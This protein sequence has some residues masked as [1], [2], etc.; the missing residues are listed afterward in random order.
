MI[1][2]INSLYLFLYFIYI[3]NM[4]Y[5]IINIE[6]IKLHLNNIFSLENRKKNTNLLSNFIIE[7]LNKLTNS[8]STYSFYILI[9][10]HYIIVFIPFLYFYFSFKIDYKFYISIIII[11]F[12]FAFHFYFNG[13]ILIRTERK[14][15]NDKNWYGI[16]NILFIPLQMIGVEINS[17]L[18]NNI[19]ICYGIITIF[20]LFI[21]ILFF[22]QISLMVKL[23]FN[24][25]HKY[26]L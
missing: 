20:F 2:Y 19:F 13:C 6:Y 5:N 23:I 11:F 9:L 12:I 17:K 14:I 16:W 8:N 7:K 21:K 1:I 22:E 3:Y 26:L 15:L 18:I 10:F 4:N 24:N 25:I